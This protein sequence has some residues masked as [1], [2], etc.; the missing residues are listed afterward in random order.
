M[1]NR[2]TKAIYDQRLMSLLAMSVN[3]LV[4]REVQQYSLQWRQVKDIKSDEPWIPRLQNNHQFDFQFL[5]FL[6]HTVEIF[7]SFDMENAEN[8]VNFNS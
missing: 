6:V 2:P 7:N 5:D 3:D 8:K 1:W 4:K